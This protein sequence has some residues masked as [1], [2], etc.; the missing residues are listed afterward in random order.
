VGALADQVEIVAGERGGEAVGILDLRHVALLVDDPEAV[1]EGEPAAGH[2]ALPEA[3]GMQRAQRGGVA[4]GD[5]HRDPARVGYE[6]AHADHALAAGVG[7]EDREGV[8]VLAGDESVDRFWTKLS[9]W[10]GGRSCATRSGRA[11]GVV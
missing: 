11:S 5:Q 4:L 10:H 8:T 1:G 3:G 7:P 6:G 9:G 2:L